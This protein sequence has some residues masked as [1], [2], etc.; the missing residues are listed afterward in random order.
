MSENI[1]EKI[2][3]DILQDRLLYGNSTKWAN[4]MSQLTI[5]TCQ[6]CA[7]QHGTIVDISVLDNK[8]EVEAHPRCKCV[9]VPMRTKRAG[10]ATT[11]GFDGADAQL[12]YGYGLP[13][14]YMRKKQ[15]RKAGWQ[16]W[17]G[18]L[19]EV[20]PGIMIGGDIYKNNDGKL[21][22][23]CGMNAIL[24]M[25]KDIATTKEFYFQMT[26]W[27]SLHAIIITRFMKQ[28]SKEK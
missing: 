6:Y 3:N 1:V 28:Q 17:K 16:Q 18:N 24:T 10:T 19:N 23:E 8:S 13:D 2:V 9:Y 22:E 11:K 27:Y 7:E 21:P 4:W 5:V 12:L 20:L 14:Y 26:A 15:A 25:T